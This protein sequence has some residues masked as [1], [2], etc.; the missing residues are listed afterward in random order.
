MSLYSLPIHLHLQVLEFYTNVCDSVSLIAYVCGCVLLFERHIFHC[1]REW[2]PPMSDSSLIPPPS[3]GCN[4]SKPRYANLMITPIAFYSKN[5]SLTPSHHSFHPMPAENS[6]TTA[7]T[8]PSPVSNL[9]WK[10]SKKFPQPSK[11][12]RFIAFSLNGKENGEK[13]K[14][15]IDCYS[16]SL[17]ISFMASFFFSSVFLLLLFYLYFILFL[18]TFFAVRLQAPAVVQK[19]TND[20]SRFW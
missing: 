4:I 3:C 12:S 19:A 2:P 10:S 1:H 5:N 17:T 15:W 20:S 11:S 18:F 16:T 7:I 6:L 13:N 8:T 9:I 14:E